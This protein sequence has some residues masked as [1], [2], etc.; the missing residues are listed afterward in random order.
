MGLTPYLMQLANRPA[1]RW[2]GRVVEAKWTDVEAEG[3]FARWASAARSS[4]EMRETSCRG[5]RVFRGRHVFG[6]AAEATRG[7]DTATRCCDGE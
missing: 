2:S 6:D 1:W 3:P 5:D 7:F 4:M